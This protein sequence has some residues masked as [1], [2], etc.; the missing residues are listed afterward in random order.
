MYT[1]YTL[2]T[3]QTRAR[4]ASVVCRYLEGRL[5][6]HVLLAAWLLDKSEVQNYLFNQCLTI[7]ED[8]CRGSF[9]STIISCWCYTFIMHRL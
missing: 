3:V 8:S 4:G 5:L 1:L 2:C 7:S 6:V 9:C